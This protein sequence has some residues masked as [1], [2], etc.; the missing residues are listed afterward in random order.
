M[1]TFH[2][3]TARQFQ[4]GTIYDHLRLN[5]AHAIGRSLRGGPPFRC[6]N[7]GVLTA[8]ATADERA[9][10]ARLLG[11]DT[12][13]SAGLIETARRHRVHLL[14]AASMG[15]A[16]E[17]YPTLARDLKLAAALDASREQELGR[18]LHALAADEIDVL[19]LKGAGLAYTV[20]PA[21]YLRPRVD[22]DLMFRFGSLARAERVFSAH[23][24]ARSIEPTRELSSAQRHYVKPGPCGTTDH[25]DVHWKIANPR[26][27]A[28]ALSF[29]ELVARSIGVPAIGASARTLAFPD[30][31]F[32]ACLHRVA[33]HDD[34]LDLLWLWDIHL[35]VERLSPG[36]RAAFVEVAQRESMCAVCRRGLE[37]A[38]QS[39]GGDCAADLVVELRRLAAP[40]ERSARFIGGIRPAAV[41][42]SDL[43]SLGGW[44][45]RA[46]LVLEHVFPSAAY[47]Q[48]I[49]PRCPSVLL[50][51]A[52]AH[53]IFRGIPRWFQILIARP[54][55]RLCAMSGSGL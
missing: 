5:I 28:D 24:W 2:E 17:L 50:P 9:I 22:T 54:S 25:L 29:D 26:V 35:L 21:P 37:L 7:F 13:L 46:A 19:L 8:T 49:Y 12:P 3:L 41:L 40:D 15:T 32:L 1:G 11:A 52:Y 43:A 36:E 18:L 6:H 31:L 30:A 20:Y 44:R 53:R 55:A 47:L 38:S 27:F 48:W 10:C 16:S 33:H 34:A 39:F 45:A 4:I 23:G 51:L 14:L 42:G